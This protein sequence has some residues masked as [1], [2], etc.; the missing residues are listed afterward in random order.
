M[1]DIP[2]ISVGHPAGGQFTRHTRPESPLRLV[3]PLNEIDQ[4]R[5]RNALRNGRNGRGAEWSPE[6]RR[7]IEEVVNR[8][9]SD[10]WEAARSVVINQKAFQSLWS[11]VVEHTD[12]QVRELPADG[13]WP[14]I[15]TRQ[16][17]LIALDVGTRTKEK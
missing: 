4:K 15:P 16:Q 2:R 7:R 12:Y 14:E 11:A 8:P 13:N 6:A 10:S 3:E 1:T 5:L 17:I 9:T